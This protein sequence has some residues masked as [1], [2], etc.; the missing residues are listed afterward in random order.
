MTTAVFGAVLLCVAS[1]KGHE[2]EIMADASSNSDSGAD[3]EDDPPEDAET[4]GCPAPIHPNYCRSACRTFVSRLEKLHASRMKGRTRAG[5]GT[6][7]GYFVFAENEMTSTGTTDR[8]IVE[9]YDSSSELVGV[10]DSR[11]ACGRY[12]TIPSCVPHIEWHVHGTPRPDPRSELTRLRALLDARQRERPA[13][14]D[15]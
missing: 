14:R 13:S 2:R 15:E 4:S 5:L 8:G 6:C 9:Y 1:C 7:G 11:Q 10:T 12:G 3:E